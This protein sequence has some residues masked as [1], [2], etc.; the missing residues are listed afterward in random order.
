MK[1]KQAF[2]QLAYQLIYPAVLGSIIFDLADPFRAMTE[3]RIVGFFICL[4]FIV[5]YLHMT[6]NLCK[7]GVSPH[8]Y[9][10]AVDIL[11]A[12]LFCLS[13][14]SLSRT[15]VPDFDESLLK[16]YLLYSLGYIFL[17]NLV[18]LIYEMPMKEEMNFNI[19]EYIPLIV[20]GSGLVVLFYSPLEDSLHVLFAS[21]LIIFV[22]Y[23][24]RVI[25]PNYNPNKDENFDT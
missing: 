4:C 11:I 20:S 14:F 21:L 9:G 1:L 24:Y 8:K 19:I 25:K 2:N 3:V 23:T 22:T 5:D 18:I 15:T 12:L 17:A 16:T 10:A 13:Y 6:L 7:D